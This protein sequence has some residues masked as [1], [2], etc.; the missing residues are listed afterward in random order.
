[1][2][3][4]PGGTRPCTYCPRPGADVC[5][6][7]NPASAEG[8]APHLYAHRACA[9]KLDVPPVHAFADGTTEL[10]PACRLGEHGYCRPG[11]VRTS[12]ADLALPARRCD[13][14][15]HTDCACHAHWRVPAEQVDT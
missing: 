9:S 6:R 2:A 15:C 8:A 10:L 5:I 13:C 14:P 11:A 7:T 1:M 3:D 4:R 12:Y